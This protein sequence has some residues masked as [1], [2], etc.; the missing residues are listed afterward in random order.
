M[1]SNNYADIFC[2]LRG[3][4]FGSAFFLAAKPILHSFPSSLRYLTE[5]IVLFAV[6]YLIYCISQIS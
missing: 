1:Q 5:A 2:S 3:R 4:F 6:L